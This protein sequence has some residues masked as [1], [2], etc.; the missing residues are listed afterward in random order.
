MKQSGGG[1]YEVC[2]G[3][4]ESLLAGGE[5]LRGDRAGGGQGFGCQ[6]GSSG[7]CS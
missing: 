6:P 7:L 1:D 4:N 2:E 5:A 3:E